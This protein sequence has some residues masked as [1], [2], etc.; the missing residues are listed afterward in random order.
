MI[1]IPFY[2]HYRE[3][4]TVISMNLRFN[5]YDANAE[6]FPC[7][8]TLEPGVVIPSPVVLFHG[9]RGKAEECYIKAKARI[10]ENPN[11]LFYVWAINI[12]N[13]DSAWQ[14]LLKGHVKP[15]NVRSI[16]SRNVR[17]CAIDIVSLAGGKA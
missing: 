13:T 11:T 8:C 17:Q 9:E 15:A 12:D 1:R 2:N 4:S 7:L 6:E 10:L 16:D 5:I 14:L 3:G